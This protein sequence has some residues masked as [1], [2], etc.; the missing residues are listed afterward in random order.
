MSASASV[1]ALGSARPESQLKMM[2][3]PAPTAMN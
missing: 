3:T 1:S 2:E